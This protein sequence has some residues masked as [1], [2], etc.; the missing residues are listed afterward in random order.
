RIAS[1]QVVS[2]AVVV[3]NRIGTAAAP[4]EAGGSEVAP[5]SVCHVHGAGDLPVA[6]AVVLDDGRAHNQH[7]SIPGE[8][9]LKRQV[10]G[11][12]QHAVSGDVSAQGQIA[13]DHSAW[14]VID[15]SVVGDIPVGIAVASRL[16]ARVVGVVGGADLLRS[17][18]APDLTDDTGQVARIRV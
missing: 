15:G 17:R 16:G 8:V 3:L 13:I 4:T 14:N 5:L 9:A 6:A 12:N 11:D 7:H 18:R 10:A 1:Q 2:P